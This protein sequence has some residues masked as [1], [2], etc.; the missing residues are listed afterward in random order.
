MDLPAAF[1]NNIFGYQ[2]AFHHSLHN[3]A[4]LLLGLLCPTFA[5]ADV[6]KTQGREISPTTIF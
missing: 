3:H 1:A 5:D 6:V 4:V 2:L